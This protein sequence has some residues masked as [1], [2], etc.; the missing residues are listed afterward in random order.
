MKNQQGLPAGIMSRRMGWGGGSEKF[1]KTDRQTDRHTHT[2]R[3]YSDQISRS[4]LRE[5][6]D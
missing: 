5:L 2:Y 3:H 1:H 6:R 4:A